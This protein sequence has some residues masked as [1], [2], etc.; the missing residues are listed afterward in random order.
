MQGRT[1]RLKCHVKVVRTD[2][3]GR[4]KTKECGMKFASLQAL[5]NHTERSH[6]GAGREL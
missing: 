6:G 3:K 2:R 5:V 4:V 1:K